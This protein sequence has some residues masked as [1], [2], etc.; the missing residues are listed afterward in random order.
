MMRP[1]LEVENLSVDLQSDG[2]WRSVVRH[3]SFTLDAGQTLALV[4]ESGSGKSVTAAAI[5]RILPKKSTRVTGSVL[6][7]GQ[8]LL[9]LSEKQMRAV[10][11]GD[12]GIV[13]QEDCLNPVLTIGYQLMEHLIQHQQ[14]S[15][16]QARQEAIGLLKK[17]R[18]SAAETRMDDYP[19]QLSGGM[20]QRVMI[21][22]ALAGRPK[23]LIADEPTTA[24]DVTIQAQIMALLKQLQ[25]EEGMAVLFITHDM[26]LVA[27]MADRTLVMQAGEVKET[28][29]TAALFAHPQDTYTARLLAAARHDAL[30]P[31]APSA[32]EPLLEIEGLTCRFNLRGGLLGRVKQR[33]HAVEQISL[34]LRRG[35]TLALV[36]ESGS[37]KSTLGRAL[38]GLVAPQAGRVLLNGEQIVAPGLPLRT[39]RACRVQMIFQDPWSSLNARMTVGEAIAEPWIYHRHGDRHQARERV[40]ELLKLVGLTPGMATRYP[41]EFSGGQRQRI[42]IAR[43]LIMEPE[44]IIAD[45]S[46]SALDALVK[47][48]VMQLLSDLQHKL[49]TAFLFISHDMSVVRQFSHRVAVMQR[50][51]IV[52]TGRNEDIFQRAQHPYTRRLLSAVPVAD[53]SRRSRAPE[54]DNS[55]IVHAVMPANADVPTLVYRQIAAEHQVVVNR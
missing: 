35:E 48:Q 29:L 32:A 23:V 3:I 45:E 16:R 37:G 7:N 44:V 52:E 30:P 51:V 19:H 15:R 27:E 43:A 25:R 39:D 21:A 26:G 54:L 33:V 49:G 11:G 5:M 42:C 53:P 38:V 47:M 17:V 24:L 12:I 46:V 10:R 20:R 13:F 31:T 34:Q 40:S 4:G 36:G 6:L 9:P 50:G 28:N 41:N 14:L 1:V 18:L 2:E 55:E 8:A 22:L